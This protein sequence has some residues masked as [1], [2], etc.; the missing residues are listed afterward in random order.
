MTAIPTF[1]VVSAKAVHTALLGREKDVIDLVERAYLLHGEGRTVNP[2]S[3]FLRF[4]DAPQNRIIALPAA[5]SDD[6]VGGLKW[7][8]S[9][10]GNVSAGIPRA[11]AVL[12]LNDLAT[13]YPVACLESSIISASRTAA[14]AALAAVRLGTGRTG[15]P[16]LGFFGA[17]LIARYVHTYLAAAGLELAEIAVHDHLEEHARA[18]M[19]Y[20]ER[21]DVDCPARVCGVAESLVRS[22]DVVVF[23]TTA[24]TPHMHDPE[25]FSHNP[26]VLHL[27]LR[28]LASEV[29]LRCENVEHCLKANNLAAPGG[30]V[31][32]QP[33]PRA[34]HPLRRA[35]RRLPPAGEP[36]AGVLPL[37]VGRAGPRAS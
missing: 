6:G 28:D 37:R 33:R 9:F 32:R 34:R 26:L 36:A 8:S 30:A 17:G 35:A 22:A 20:Q 23:A 19:S 7:I 4:P 10:P 29:V 27:S 31:H 21:F 2:P 3:Y 15:R 14:S 11:S 12:V 16:R 18:F 24:G 5:V 25:W 13:G 1:S